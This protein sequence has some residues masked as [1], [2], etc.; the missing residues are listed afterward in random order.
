[1]FEYEQLQEEFDSKLERWWFLPG[2]G[3]S[4][5][6]GLDWDSRIQVYSLKSGIRRLSQHQRRRGY[7]VRMTVDGKRTWRSIKKLYRLYGTRG[8]YD[9]PIKFKQPKRLASSYDLKQVLDDGEKWGY[10]LVKERIIELKS[11]AVTTFG[12]VFNLKRC[13]VTEVA[14]T[15]DDNGT[16]VRLYF[17]GNMTRPYVKS[18]M[19]EVFG[20]N[21]GCDPRLNRIHHH[22]I[23]RG[24]R[25]GLTKKVPDIEY[26]AHLSIYQN[27]ERNWYGQRDAFIEVFGE[28]AMRQAEAKKPQFIGPTGY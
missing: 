11:Y 4:Y 16:R 8:P 23:N 3:G 28:E 1:M 13:K 26:Y 17:D 12:R 6:V 2:S 14:Q 20:T 24:N 21:K 15:R 18:L 7:Y 25:R 5:V 9:R 27:G 10:V 19:S 22:R